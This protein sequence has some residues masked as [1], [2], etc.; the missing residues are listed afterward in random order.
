MIAKFATLIAGALCM[1]G[2]VIET[3]GPTQHDSRSI[4]LDK[5]EL[6]RVDLEM[7]AGNLR[8]DSG[9]QQLMRADFT[10]NVASWKPYV[11]YDKGPVRGNLTIEQP[12]QHQAHMG[13]SKYEWDVR[14][15]REVPLDVK[16][17]FGA[18]H[19]LMVDVINPA[20]GAS[21]RV[22]LELNAESAR[23]LA[24]AILRS[25][26]GVPAGLLES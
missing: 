11:R 8:V 23:E 6:V 4:E 14:L 19:A 9:T 20:L 13:G 24:L 7:G 26:D 5:S 10:Y 1:C 17:H 16:V 2:C 3:S 21:S 22:G 12:L 15:N 25:L 18:G